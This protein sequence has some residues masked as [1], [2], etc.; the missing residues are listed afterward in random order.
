MHDPLFLYP[1]WGRNHLCLANNQSRTKTIANE[2]RDQYTLYLYMPAHD[3]KREREHINTSQIMPEYAFLDAAPLDD[4]TLQY[5][6][7][8][9]LVHP[10]T[11][12][13]PPRLPAILLL[14]IRDAIRRPLVAMAHS[15]RP[16]AL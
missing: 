11:L 6:H 10:P 4:L 12:H 15:G 5:L 2:R 9:S 14:P 3:Q 7:P 8:A 1:E 13:N 16:N